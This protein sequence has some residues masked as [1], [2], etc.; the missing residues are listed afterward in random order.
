MEKTIR[1]LVTELI[2]GS[3]DEEK[4]EVIRYE[5]FDGEYPRFAILREKQ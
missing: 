2:F 3:I 4:W 5:E 1:I